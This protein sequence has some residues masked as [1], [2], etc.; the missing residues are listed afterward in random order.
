M[1]RNEEPCCK[2]IIMKADFWMLSATLAS[3][4]MAGKLFGQ[5]P[6]I[7]EGPGTPATGQPAKYR[8]HLQGFND[9]RSRDFLW[10]ERTMAYKRAFAMI[11]KQAGELRRWLEPDNA[12]TRGL[13]DQIIG[14]TA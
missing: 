4:L 12:K 2:G 6:P 8:G 3:C 14:H 10:D 9:P 5:N 13:L 1:A 11:R 7:L